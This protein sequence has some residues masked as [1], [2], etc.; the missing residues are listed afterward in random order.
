MKYIPLLFL[1]CVSLVAQPSDKALALADSMKLVEKYSHYY[2]KYKSHGA[3]TE[4]S[5]ELLGQ[6]PKELQISGLRT[7]IA[8]HLEDSLSPEE[9]DQAYTFF[10]TEAGKKLGIADKFEP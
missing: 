7:M 9:L 2:G 1:A 3:T 10:Q 6:L 8:E 5:Q 4:V